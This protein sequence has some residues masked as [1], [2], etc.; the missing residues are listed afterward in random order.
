VGS[1]LLLGVTMEGGRGACSGRKNRADVRNHAQSAFP[2]LSGLLCSIKIYKSLPK[3]PKLQTCA[4]V[5]LATITDIGYLR[6]LNRPLARELFVYPDRS[7][8]LRVVRSAV[9]RHDTAAFCY[10]LQ[11]GREPGAIVEVRHAQPKQHWHMRITDGRVQGPAD[12]PQLVVRSGCRQ[13]Q[14]QVQNFASK[15]SLQR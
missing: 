10:T 14:V 1:G 12:D 6:K 9:Q 7:R 4:K 15:Q 2:E 11:E 3:P 5:S 13:I 8:L